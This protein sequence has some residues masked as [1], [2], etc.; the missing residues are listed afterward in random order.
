MKDVVV[1]KVIDTISCYFES[2]PESDTYEVQKGALA[3]NSNVGLTTADCI[4]Q[5]LASQTL[6]VENL[7][8][9]IIVDRPGWVDWL[10][11]R[12]EA[13]RKKSVVKNELFYANHELTIPEREL[14]RLVN[15]R[16]KVLSKLA[17][18]KELIPKVKSE[19]EAIKEHTIR[20]KTPKEIADE[21]LAARELERQ[22]NIEFLERENSED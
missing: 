15:E 20:T 10:E 22:E 19:I 7:R 5:G 17:E 12:R 11:V 18:R 9:K 13:A 21:Y 2:N 3:F 16:D 1:N 14:N 6:A 8:G 4:C